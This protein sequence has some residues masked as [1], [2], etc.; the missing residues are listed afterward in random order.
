MKIDTVGQ[1]AMLRGTLLELPA[2]RPL[3]VT[4]AGG[5]LWLTLDNDPRDLVLDHGQRVLLK[6]PQRVLAYA[7]DDALMDVRKSLVDGLATP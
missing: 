2:T 3:E 7:L 4:S 1:F 5:T 6:A